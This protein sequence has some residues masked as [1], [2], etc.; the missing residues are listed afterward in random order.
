LEAENDGSSSARAFGSLLLASSAGLQAGDAG[1]KTFFTL[2]ARRSLQTPVGQLNVILRR[3]ED[4]GIHFY[5]VRSRSITSLQTDRASGAATLVASASLSDITNPFRPV[6]LEEQATALIGLDD[7]GR[8]GA[9]TDGLRITVWNESGQL[10]FSNNWDGVR[11]VEQTIWRG[12]V[13]VR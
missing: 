1:S 10:W 2:N 11:T 4:D 9:L 3:T 8:P 12:D 13:R 6:L 5:Q 7:N